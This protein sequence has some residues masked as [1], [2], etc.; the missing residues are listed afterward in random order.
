[1]P[2]KVRST[3][4]WYRLRNALLP[5]F[6]FALSLTC[7]LFGIWVFSGTRKRVQ[8]SLTISAGSV[9]GLR[10]NFIEL[11]EEVTDGQ[12]NA[13]SDPSRSTLTFRQVPSGGS[14][15]SLGRVESGELDL[16]LVQG[17]L[18]TKAYQSV[19]QVASLHVEP[20]HLV[21]KP[22]LFD[23]CHEHLLAL[24]GRTI[25]VGTRGSGTSLLSTQVLSFAGLSET[26]YQ[27]NG[28]SYAELIRQAVSTD[29]VPTDELP[30][31]VFAISSLPSPVV[32]TL[33]AQ[34]GYRLVSLPVA[35]PIRRT[36]LTDRV[37]T[38][39]DEDTALGLRRIERF[40]IPRMTYLIDP[41]R[42]PMTIETIGTRL[43]LV[44]NKDVP[45]QIVA[46]LARRVYESEIARVTDQKISWAE[47]PEL[48]EFPLHRGAKAY[49]ADKQPIE[50][51][52]LIEVTEQLV[53]IS[54]AL[55]GTL[56]FVWQWL[57]RQRSNRRDAAFVDYIDRVI[58]IENEALSYE[59]DEQA[60]IGRLQE[61]QE[62]LSVLKVE[63][64]DR[65]RDG[66]LEGTEMLSSFLKHANDTSELIS[67][68]ILHRIQ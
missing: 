63:L 28:D 22:T 7:L 35:T 12:Q 13:E 67:R 40:E 24:R 5:G 36:W 50:T 20:L 2:L 33:I 39:V 45:E 49:L 15:D 17:G 65:F 6:G 34:R 64:I 46:D 59:D 3:I 4:K 41:P 18:P 52:R 43:N 62:E 60:P 53:G 42:P 58:R 32:S 16:A 54:G 61:M 25:A 29:T 30:D 38:V 10:S 8:S 55:L 26:D 68:I 9:L 51:G 66:V 37:G 44:A 31:A 23:D 47:L 1:M 48:A 19:R 56:L 27:A 21:V 57:R 14:I 11:L